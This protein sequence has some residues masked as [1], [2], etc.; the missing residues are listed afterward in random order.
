[1]IVLGRAVEAP[2]KPL[3]VVKCYS[4]A[5][6]LREHWSTAKGQCAIVYDNLPPI[7]YISSGLAPKVRGRKREGRGISPPTP[8]RE[9]EDHRHHGVFWDLFRDHR[10]P[11][12][13]W[14]V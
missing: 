9:I 2:R 3:V 7:V 13:L 4:R 14:R 6:L 11:L 10:Y 12:R 1:L 8:R 5:F